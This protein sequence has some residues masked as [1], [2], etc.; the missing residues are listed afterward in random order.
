M[1][2]II[3]LLFLSFFISSVSFSQRLDFKTRILESENFNLECRITEETK[4]YPIMKSEKSIRPNFYKIEP[5]LRNFNFNL[6][7]YKKLFVERGTT[8]GTSIFEYENIEINK[9]RTVTILFSSIVSWQDIFQ[10]NLINWSL[11]SVNNKNIIAQV[12]SYNL[13]L[14]NNEFRMS[15][16]NLDK[17]NFENYIQN[18][19]RPPMKDKEIIKDDGVWKKEKEILS[20]KSIYEELFDKGLHVRSFKGTCRKL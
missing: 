2:K 5:V 20:E 15:I 11:Q 8:V 14:H 1:K 13:L 9:K 17:E 6:S 10:D 18:Q 4:N 12:Y 19:K 7:N 3:L 16:Y